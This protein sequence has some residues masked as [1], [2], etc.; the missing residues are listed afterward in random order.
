MF[1]FLWSYEAANWM[2]ITNMQRCFVSE[3]IKSTLLWICENVICMNVANARICYFRKSRFYNC[4]NLSN[5]CFLWRSRVRA[6]AIFVSSWILLYVNFRHHYLFEK[7]EFVHFLFLW[8]HEFCIAVNFRTLNFCNLLKL[9]CL[10]RSRLRAFAIFVNSWILLILHCRHHYL[11]EKLE[12]VHFLFLWSHESCIAVNFRIQS[13]L[14]Y[15]NCGF[16]ES[17]GFV[18]LL[19]LWTHEFDCFWIFDITISLKS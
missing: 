8:S 7:V 6:F 2:N 5:K 15:W 3:A 18:H 11:S 14:I 17:R 19:F 12:F 16:Y 9:R 4:C 13:F 1:A 10:W